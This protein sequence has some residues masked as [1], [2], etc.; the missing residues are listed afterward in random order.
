MERPALILSVSTKLV[1][2]RDF[3]VLVPFT[4]TAVVLWFISQVQ[5]TARDRLEHVTF[6]R[7]RLRAAL[8]C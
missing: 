6:W 2:N 8:R 1:P 4:L 7:L 3:V 5:L